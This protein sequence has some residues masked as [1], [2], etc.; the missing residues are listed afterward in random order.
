MGLP[1]PV[2]H[3]EFRVAANIHLSKLVCVF[4]DRTAFANIL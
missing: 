3:I 4:K 1:I 2:W